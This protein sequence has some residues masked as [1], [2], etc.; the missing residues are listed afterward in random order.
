MDNKHIITRFAPSPTGL[1]HVGS[2][3]ASLFNYLFAKKASGKIYLRIE[4]TDRE[5]S[6]PEFEQNILDSLAWLGLQF[7]NSEPIRQS[8]TCLRLMRQSN[9]PYPFKN[10]PCA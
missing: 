10:Y 9:F 8:A 5:R 2:A 7:D 3:R 1:L 6:K 4:D